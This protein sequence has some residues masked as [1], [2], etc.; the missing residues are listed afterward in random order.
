MVIQTTAL[1]LLAVYFI[2]YCHID[3]HIDQITDDLINVQDFSEDYDDGQARSLFALECG[4]FQIYDSRRGQCKYSKSCHHLH[5]DSKQGEKSTMK[6][7]YIVLLML[8][9]ITVVVAF[10]QMQFD[11]EEMPDE[12]GDVHSLCIFCNCPAGQV[13]DNHK[14]RFVV[15]LT[16]VFLLSTWTFTNASAVPVRS[17]R[18]VC[19]LCNV[20]C[21]PGYVF[22]DYRERCVR[23][24]RFKRVAPLSQ[25]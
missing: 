18:A 17:E 6:L 21:E 15:L 1:C 2:G 10:P 25:V 19:H 12:D 9:C 16:V 20:E 8:M 4:S 3:E 24:R 5:I 13:F 23:L 11:E 7:F 22:D 14:M